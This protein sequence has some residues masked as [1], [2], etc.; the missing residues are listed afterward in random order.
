M[1][2]SVTSRQQGTSMIEVLVA[3]FI[4]AVGLLGL[5]SLQA[6]LQ[7]LQ[8][9]SYQRAQALMLLGDMA[10]RITL[11]RE[12]AASYATAVPVGVG[13]SC[14]ASSATRLEAD[15]AEWCELL[16]GAAETRGATQVGAMVG[17]RGC[18][19]PLGS[20]EYLV[21][22]AWQGMAP[23]SAPPAGVTCGAGSYG[24]AAGT[25]CAGDVCRRVVTT[26]VRIAT[27]I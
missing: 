12:N 3:M 1:S 25:P 10:T 5:I 7:I 2:N 22:V 27:L 16:Q 20:N 11:N 23:I 26:V 9:E 17:A 13:M 18:I 19:Q 14:P 4:I 6:K 8:M 21:T 24:G 15:I